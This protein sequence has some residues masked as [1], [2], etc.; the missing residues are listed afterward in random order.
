MLP[1]T[2]MNGFRTCG[3]FPCD[4][5]RQQELLSAIALQDSDTRPRI[6]SENELDDI[7]SASCEDENAHQTL[8][9]QKHGILVSSCLLTCDAS[10]REIQAAKA[11]KLEQDALKLK[12]KEVRDR[13]QQERKIKKD[14]A[15]IKRDNIKKQRE[16]NLLLKQ[17]QSACK[18][19][20]NR[21]KKKPRAV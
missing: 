2:L 19:E 13:K 8:T 12:S 7:L 21:P 4:P 9:H 5:K 18:T 1:A 6:V 17:N 3:F 15:D 20:S 11:A 16:A 10:L 14:L